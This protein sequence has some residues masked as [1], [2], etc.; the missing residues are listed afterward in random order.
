MDVV[1]DAIGTDKRIG[2]RYLTGGMGFGGPCF[3]RDNVA[4]AFAAE[5]LGVDCSLLTANDDF[6]R[7]ISPRFA[8]RLK[9]HIAEGSTVAVLGLAYKPFSHV[10]EE[11]AGI[12]LARALA[13]AGY[14]VL[15][16]DPLAGESAAAVL[17]GHVLVADNLADCVM[18]AKAV[19]ITTADPAFK[20]LDA[21]QFCKGE[22]DVL[23]VDFWRLLAHEMENKPGI[24]Y[25]PIGKCLDPAAATQALDSIW[26]D[27]VRI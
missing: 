25:M 14:R 13:D 7:S 20:A 4:L 12:Y 2:R 5:A 11:S 1:S 18:D 19:L 10:V 22:D 3:P 16:Y 6:N 9:K 17:D 8:D 24:R 23:V 26:K 21:S 15:G 27:A